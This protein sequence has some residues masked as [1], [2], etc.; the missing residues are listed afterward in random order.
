MPV[1]ET[2][3]DPA[4]V[5]AVTAVFAEHHDVIVLDDDVTTFETVIT[6]LVLLFGHTPRRAS[7]LAW[8]VHVTGEAVVATLPLP[9]AEEGVRGLH[10][11]QILA[12]IRP[13]G[14]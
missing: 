8:T 13:T 11:Y 1:T 10:R 9:E 12:T 5:A 4:L 2:A 3:V 14:S 6:A 7:E